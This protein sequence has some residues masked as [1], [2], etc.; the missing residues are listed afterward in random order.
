MQLLGTPL[1]LVVA[2]GVGCVGFEIV[3][4]APESGLPLLEA[5]Y[6][7]GGPGG[8]LPRATGAG[9]LST[10]RMGAPANQAVTS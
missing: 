4:V 1:L 6:D 7:A 2:L 5:G 10:P 3:G 9:R 8:P